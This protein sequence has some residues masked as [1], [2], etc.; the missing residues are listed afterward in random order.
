MQ[1]RFVVALEFMCTDAG[2]CSR[3]VRLWLVGM[4]VAGLQCKQV[5]CLH[6]CAPGLPSCSAVLR[7]GCSKLCAAAKWLSY[8]MADLCEALQVGMR[9]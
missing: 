1:C 5:S 8:I 9:C 6:C 4:P 7:P 3:Q 2:V